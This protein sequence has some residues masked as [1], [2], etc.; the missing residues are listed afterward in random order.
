METDT[1]ATDTADT[2]ETKKLASDELIRAELKGEFLAVE[3]Y[4]SILWKIRSGYVVAL[5]GG[6][7][8]LGG[9]GLKGSASCNNIRFLVA[10]ISLIWG[11]S[12]CGL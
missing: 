1:K 11:F 10:M 12:I 6:L 3:R 4:D 9:N 2:I 7:A 5:Y 8:V